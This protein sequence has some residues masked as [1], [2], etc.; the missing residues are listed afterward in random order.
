MNKLK[1]Y[2]IDV[3]YIKY[4][5]SFDKRVQFN[6][7]REDIYSEKRP[8]LGIVLNINDFNYYVPLEHPRPNH[9]KMKNNTFIFKI[10][11]G[12]FGILG[13][14][15]MIPVKKDSIIDFDINKEDI[16]YRNILIRQYH[17]N[18]YIEESLDII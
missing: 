18:C 2:K 1:L 13:F 3:N 8:Y 16:K 17:I 4:L 9:Q 15:N 5:Y 6:P 10:Q 7:Q 14:N 12:R 11:N